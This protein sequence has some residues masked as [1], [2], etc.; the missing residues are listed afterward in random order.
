MPYLNGP[1]II[2]QA[3]D[4]FGFTFTQ[5]ERILL[6]TPARD[7]YDD[8]HRILLLMALQTCSCPACGLLICRR[9]A[10]GLTLFTVPATVRADDDYACPGCK[11]QLTWHLGMSGSQ[12]F[13][14][15]RPDAVAL[16]AAE[17]AASDDD[18]PPVTVL[19]PGGGSVTL[20]LGR[21]YVIRH[22]VSG[23]RGDH[24]SR[25]GFLGRGGGVLLFDARPDAGTVK[26]RDD[27]ILAVEPAVRDDAARFACRKVAP[28]A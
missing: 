4:L 2:R 6:T 12:W 20:R 15:T 11:V 8:Q 27:M 14:V 23:E 5:H 24:Q 22:T 7:P 18:R 16:D 17:R 3:E 13:T 19:L 9:S 1:T 28:D 21:E 10:A 26:L 25:M